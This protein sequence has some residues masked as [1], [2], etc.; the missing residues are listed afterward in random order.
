MFADRGN[1]D[2]TEAEGDP[3]DG[4]EI[5]PAVPESP[6]PVRGRGARKSGTRPRRRVLTTT[7]AVAG[8]LILVLVGSIPAVRTVLRQSFTRQPTPYTELYFSGTP[9]VDGILL[10]VPVTVVNHATGMKSFVLRVWMTDAAGRTDTTSSVTVTPRTGQATTVVQVSLQLPDGA[11]VLWVNLAGQAQ[12]LHDR[13][14][15]EAFPS[16][17]ASASPTAGKHG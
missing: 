14:A 9:K 3:Q 11:Q 6:A 5:P 15:G 7:A 12:T 8:V 2:L 16:P 17:S 1:A 10:T 4:E 13:I